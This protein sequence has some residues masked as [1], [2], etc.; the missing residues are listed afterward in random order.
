MLV[1]GL[2]GPMGSGKST[3]AS[4]LVAQ[5]DMQG[6]KAIIVPMAKPLKE[7][8]RSFGWDGKKDAKGRRFLQILGTE[9]GRA[10]DADFWT[11]KWIDA[12]VKLEMEADIDVVIVDDVRFDNEAITIMSF[13][14][15]VFELAGRNEIPVWRLLLQHQFG[16]LY[17][18][19]H[20]SEVPL[21]R[22]LVYNVR[23]NTPG[24]ASLLAREI[25]DDLI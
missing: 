5:L 24:Q 17:S 22:D 19:V 6:K 23:T 7:M 20:R 18:F 4:L 3:I 9:I 15:K 13:K 10:Y 1:I 21:S 12:I 14:G 2:S 8:A 11:G 25:L 16:W